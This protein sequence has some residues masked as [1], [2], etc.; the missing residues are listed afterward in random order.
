[1][2]TDKKIVSLAA[3]KRNISRL[4]RQG[5]TIAFTNGCF[6]ILHY[7]HVSYLESAKKHN[8]VLIVGLNSDSSVK[9]IKGSKRPIIKQK[10]RAV[11]LAALACVDFVV[12]FK[13]ETPLNLIRAVKPDVLIKGADWKNKT[14]VGS[15][16]VK[17][18]GGKMEFIK[19]LSNFSTTNIIETIAKRWGRQFK[20]SSIGLSTRILTAPKKD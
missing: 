11:L 3:L 1:M 12:I 15:D 14:A 9:K 6:D 16:I 4:R 17:S 7:G 20:K 2:N 19:Y 18:Y 5:K 10:E 8:R 13:E